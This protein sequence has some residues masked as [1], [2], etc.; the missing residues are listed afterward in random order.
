MPSDVFNAILYAGL[1]ILAITFLLFSLAY[2]TGFIIPNDDFLE[3]TQAELDE[4][5]REL[6]DDLIDEKDEDKNRPGHYVM[7]KWFE[8]G[9]GYYGL[10]V[11][12]TFFHLEFMEVLELGSTLLNVDGVES[13]IEAILQFIIQLAVESIMNVV[14][15]FTWWIHWSQQLPISGSGFLWIGV[16]YLGYLAGEWLARFFKK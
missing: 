1:P 7:H 8:F 6:R 14:H 9:G 3:E 16:S 4:I 2:Y 15:A 12:I 10:M 11:L 13:F 5:D